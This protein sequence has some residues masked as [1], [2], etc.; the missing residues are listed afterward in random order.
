MSAPLL[1]VRSV[2]KRFP[3]VKALT[4]VHLRVDRGEVVAVIG[5]N[6]AGKSTLMKILAGVQPPDEGEIWVEGSPV[7]MA[8]VREAEGLGIV[9]IHQEL[10]LCDNLDVASSLFLGREPRRFGFVLR[11]QMEDRARIPMRRVGLECSPR[12]RMDT[13]SLGR[14]QMVEIARA[15][16]AEARLLIMDEPTSSLSQGE[17]E[18]LYQVIKELR[19]SGVSIVYISHRLGEVKEL[20]DRVVVL[21]DGRNAGALNHAEI[22]HD[23]MVRLMVG[24]DLKPSHRQTPV[25]GDSEGTGFE[26]RELRSKAHARHR[27]SFQLRPG[28]IVG[29]AGLVG[30]G[31]TELL[32]ALFGIDVSAGGEV[33]LNG[34]RLDIRS[35]QDA[36]RHGLALVPEDRKAQGVILEMAVEDNT[37]LAGLDRMARMGWRRPAEERDCAGEQVE[38][39][40][41]KTPHLGQWVQYLS[42]GNQQKVV[43]A[44]WLAL[45]P[46]VLLLDEPTRGIDVG[47]KQEIYRLMGELAAGGV[48]ILFASSEMEEIL[49]MSDRVLVMHQGR[50]AGALGADTMGEEAIMKLAT[51]H[52]SA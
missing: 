18:K 36:I 3:G 49:R 2:S 52:A 8:G 32:R 28:E 33:F 21:R 29:L 11:R 12:T 14:Q 45:K 42:G 24:R 10:N 48:M 9:L 1:E 13:L 35:P 6:G 25:T 20:A 23:A 15:L 7:S 31:R 39:L 50:L 44:K 43:L 47:A 5:E 41:I 37:I 34:I 51:G 26:V 30:S 27:V 22:N 46:K 17:T 40:K 4:Q 16:S 19:S 38:K